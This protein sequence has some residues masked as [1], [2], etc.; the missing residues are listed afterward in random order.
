MLSQNFHSPQIY[1]F[2]VRATDD[3]GNTGDWFTYEWRTDFEPPVIEGIDSFLANCGNSLN[4]E[5][6]G[7]QVTVSCEI[8]D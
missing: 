3:V 1:R 4:V 6:I 2:Y 5:D 8:F 7:G